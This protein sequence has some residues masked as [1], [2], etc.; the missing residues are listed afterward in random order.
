LAIRTLF[1]GSGRPAR[2]GD[3]WATRTPIKK[4][5]NVANQGSHSEVRVTTGAM[6]K[7]INKM[8]HREKITA[9]QKFVLG[10]GMQIH[11]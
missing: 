8:L 2:T 7:A 3:R 5:S 11:E 1:I 6:P 4:P 9:K 10:G